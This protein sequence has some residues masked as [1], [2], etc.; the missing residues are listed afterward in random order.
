MKS[1]FSRKYN[2]REHT[3]Q[4]MVLIL[5]GNTEDAARVFSNLRQMPHHIADLAMQVRIYISVTS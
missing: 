1:T 5:D 3:S 2:I 4:I